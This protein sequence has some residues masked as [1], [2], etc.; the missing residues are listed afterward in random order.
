MTDN[1]VCVT[2]EKQ[3]KTNKKAQNMQFFQTGLESGHLIRKGGM[4]WSFLISLFAGKAHSHLQ[5]FF[6]GYDVRKS[7]CSVQMKYIEVVLENYFTQNLKNLPYLASNYLSSKTFNTM[8]RLLNA[9]MSCHIF[10]L[11][12]LHKCCLEILHS[13]KKRALSSNLRQKNSCSKTTQLRF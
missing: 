4:E 10:H 5:N 6:C 9:C 12:I 11:I 8:E 13:M 1:N 7:C 2:T 3:N